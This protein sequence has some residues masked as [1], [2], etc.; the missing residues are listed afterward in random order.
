MKF[1]DMEVEIKTDI[2]EQEHWHGE[3]EL[4]YV[5]QG[6]IKV[7]VEESK[8]EVPQNEM[9]LINSGKKHTVVSEKD[10]MLCQIYLPYHEI[11]DYLKEDYVLLECNS[12]LEKGYK[13]DQ[14][15]QYVKDLL[16][17]YIEGDE[18]IITRI[19]VEYKILDYLLKY[20][21]VDFGKKTGERR[22]VENQRISIIL[23][24]IYANYAET[25]SLTEIAEK[26]YMSPSSLSRF[27]KK[28]MGESFVQFVRRVRLNKAAEQLIY[29]SLSI[30]KIAV[31][32]GFSN[33][34]AMNKDFKEMY[35]ITPKEYRKQHQLDDNEKKENIETKRLSELLQGTEKKEKTNSENR[36]Y[37]ID[38]KKC[39]KYKMWKNKI[40]NIG[41]AEVLDSANM[42]KQLL[43]IKDR[44]DVKYIRIW[45]IFSQKMLFVRKEN[46]ININYSKLDG[47]LD[48]CV[49]NRLKVWFDLGQRVNTAMASNKKVIYS[50]DDTLSFASKDEWETFFEIFIE[51]ITKRY[52]RNVVEK[53]VYEFTFF[54]NAHPYYQTNHY[55]V[56]N[57]WNRGYEIVKDYIP[58]AKVAGPGLL[59]IWNEE[60]IKTIIDDFLSAEY[61]PDIFTT[62]NFPFAM[63]KK[64]EEL[65]RITD[66][67]FIAKQIQMVKR[68]L[69]EHKFKNLYYVI[70]WASSIAN[71][72]YVQDSCH[73][74]TYMLQNIITN[75]SNVDELGLW[76]AS[77]LI[78]TYFDSKG[79]L[80]GSAGLVTRDGIYK[81]IFYAYEFLNKMGAFCID[82]NSY[83]FATKDELEDVQI[84]V[85]NHKKIGPRYYMV[86]E[87]TYQP[88][89]IEDLFTNHD[90]LNIDIVLDNLEENSLYQIRQKIVSPEMGSVLEK[91]IEL[92]CGEDLLGEDIL[93]LKQIC[94]PKISIH[95]IRTKRK[96]LY[97]NLQLIPHEFRWISIK[98]K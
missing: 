67:D 82:M 8:Y 25:I 28:E 71:R 47:I 3:I 76:Y 12:L 19:S 18:Q 87:D 91:W 65:Y 92:G 44:L 17:T 15:K 31:N 69:D 75:Y 78:N 58:N 55:S 66:E 50:E 7:N 48:F 21:Y 56:K 61:K 60:I 11:C 88:K 64:N 29:T 80:N 70:E 93:Y 45:N 83:Y 22:Y 86:E 38:T 73:R 6:M 34:S 40:L 84:L 79:I 1:T 9:I 23:N 81:P 32:N 85:F 13:Y 59:L 20:F 37:L 10:S 49:E 95:D 72:N 27:F 77:D 94:T 89:E 63:K 98:K 36:K 33:P 52:G 74:A 96:K 42:R 5:I 4:L 53:W 97:L 26:V 39:K 54:V 62:I 41:A 90:C 14:L 30:S 57:V 68:I 2:E 43:E 51:H 46:K 16:M 35:G 24:Y